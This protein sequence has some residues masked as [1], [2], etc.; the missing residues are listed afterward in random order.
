MVA[1]TSQ[2]RE[3]NTKTEGGMSSNENTSDR[4][5]AVMKINQRKGRIP[6]PEVVKQIACP[7]ISP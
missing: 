7:V 4:E 3:R 5:S 2:K 1:V 6:C